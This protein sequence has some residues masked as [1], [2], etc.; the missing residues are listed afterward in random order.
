M[1]SQLY[2]EH[3]IFF[4]QSLKTNSSYTKNTMRSLLGPVKLSKKKIR[5]TK[6]ILLWPHC[7]YTKIH[8]TYFI[9]QE[10]KLAFVAPLERAAS[11]YLGELVV[12]AAALTVH[13]DSDC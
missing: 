7:F 11:S 3:A 1:E 5:F 4:I 13:L 9:R 10:S 2:A 6:I 12:L 8:I